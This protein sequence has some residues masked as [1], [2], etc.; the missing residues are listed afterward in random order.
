M[1]KNKN[2]AGLSYELGLEDNLAYEHVNSF[3]TY[4]TD[5][6]DHADKYWGPRKD[7]NQQKSLVTELVDFGLEHTFKLL[8]ISLDNTLDD[9]SPTIHHHKQE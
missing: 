5:I 8:F 6:I 4:L 7:Q 9:Q 3:T 2:P 1:L